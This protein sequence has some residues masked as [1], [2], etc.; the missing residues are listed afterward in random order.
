MCLRAQIRK[1]PRRCRRWIVRE[2]VVGEGGASG[3]GGAVVAV[4]EGGRRE[5]GGAA[6]VDESGKVLLGENNL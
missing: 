2:E 4:G 6:G 1:Y 5:E 3:S